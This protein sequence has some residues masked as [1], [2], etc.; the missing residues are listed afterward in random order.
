MSA[1]W[2]RSCVIASVLTQCVCAAAARAQQAPAATPNPPST[3][4]A[5]PTSSS[6]ALQLT[7]KQAVELA[8]KQ[9][10]QRVIAKILLSESERNSQIARAPLLPQAGFG[11]VAALNQ[12]NLQI[13]ESQPRPLDAGPYQYIDVGPGYSQTLLNLPQIRA[14]QAGREGVKQARA[15][16]RTAREIVVQAIVNQYL[17]ILQA[18]A[19]RDAAQSRVDLAQRLYEQA[20]QLQKNR[21]RLEHR[22]HARERRVAE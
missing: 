16:E 19:N 22:H 6:A 18:L 15:D 7:L 8:L 21:H 10:P 11:G 9:N 1:K 5:Q 2:L 20:T 13:V 3:P 14:Y 12:Y 17:L 4:Y